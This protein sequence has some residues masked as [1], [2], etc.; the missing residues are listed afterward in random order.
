MAT[1]INSSDYP[2]LPGSANVYIDNSLSTTL[3]LNSVSPGEKF[4][5]SLGVDK[6]IKVIYKPTQKFQ[7]Q[8]EEKIKVRILAPDVIKNNTAG[9]ES[10]ESTVSVPTVGAIFDDL[11]NL[12][13]TEIIQPEHEKEFVIKW[14]IDYP[15]NE[16]LEY[17]ESWPQE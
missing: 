1:V 8:S 17:I 14:A 6:A 15:P 2:L 9:K 12:I 7:S 16:K 4:D 5:C 11:N 13:W 3:Q 10:K